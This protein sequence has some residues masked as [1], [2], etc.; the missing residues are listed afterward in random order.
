MPKCGTKMPHLVQKITRKLKFTLY[1]SELLCYNINNQEGGIYM[2]EI[3]ESPVLEVVEYETEDV[4][5]NG[6]G[7]YGDNDFSDPWGKI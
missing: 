2:K 7:N 1:F 5:T 4:I 6:S 3:Y